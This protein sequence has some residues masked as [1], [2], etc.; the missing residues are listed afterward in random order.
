MTEF[1]SIGDAYTTTELSLTQAG[2]YYGYLDGEDDD[3]YY[4]FQPDTS[5]QFS[6]QMNVMQEGYDD[7]FDLYIYDNTF[8]ELDSSITG[9]SRETVQHNCIQGNS[10]FIRVRSYP[11]Q[12]IV[13]GL[14]AF[15]LTLTHGATTDPIF[16]FIL[17]GAAVVIIVTVI[18]VV[19][20]VQ[21]RR[22]RSRHDWQNGLVYGGSSSTNSSVSEPSSSPT[23]FCSYCGAALPLRAQ[24]CP[25]CGHVKNQ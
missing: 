1:K 9:A 14:G 19:V 15:S 6:I 3:V 2:T 7:D 25:N 12:S 24:Y 8:T 18:L 22:R 16:L 10:Y 13:D 5:S 17:A 23:S 4:R 11:S 21:L 20:I